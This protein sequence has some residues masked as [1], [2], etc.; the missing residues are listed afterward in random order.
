MPV[1]RGTQEAPAAGR[2]GTENGGNRRT[3]RRLVW[4]AA[5]CAL[6]VA[7]SAAAETVTLEPSKDNTIFEEEGDLSNGKGIHL[8]VG[9]TSTVNPA[10]VSNRRCLLAFDVAG[11]VPAGA[12]IESASL[13]LFVS[14]TIDTRPTQVTLHKLTRD[15][16]EGASI[17]GIPPSYIKDGGGAPA[18]PGDATWMFAMFD[19]VPWS[20]PGGEFVGEASATQ[21]VEDI[22][23]PTPYTWSSAAMVADVQSWLDSPESNFGWIMIG[24]ESTDTTARQ[25]NSRENTDFPMLRPMLTIEF[26]GGT[27]PTPTP[28]PLVS[29]CVGDCNSN[30]EVAINELIT[31]VNIALGRLPVDRCPSF[32]IDDDGGIEI[33]EL[34]TAVNNALAGCP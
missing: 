11:S 3:R 28:T 6:L 5:L 23:A 34:I 25:F 24:D 20:T 2:K 10:G 4:G 7:G 15:W 27:A 30:G 32:D 9:R 12:T 19:T 18:E 26:T 22:G 16:G 21:T 31:G 8:F 29:A 17:A 14:K 33:N 13:T 1:T